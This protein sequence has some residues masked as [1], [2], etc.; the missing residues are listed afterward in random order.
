MNLL[1]KLLL[2]ELS[3]LFVGDANPS[4]GYGQAMG[5]SSSAAKDAP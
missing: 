5:P 1:C 2:M 4:A 3:L